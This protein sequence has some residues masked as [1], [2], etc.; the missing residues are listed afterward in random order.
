M[1]TVSEQSIR[2]SLCPLLSFSPQDHPKNSTAKVM[3]VSVC[4]LS[5]VCFVLFC[6]S[7]LLASSRLPG[8]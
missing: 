5:L 7:K 3:L 6:F 1:E 8:S 4:Y 2:F